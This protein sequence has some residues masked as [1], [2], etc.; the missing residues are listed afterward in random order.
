MQYYEMKSY[1]VQLFLLNLFE[2]VDMRYF[3]K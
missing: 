1:E 3:N 2:D